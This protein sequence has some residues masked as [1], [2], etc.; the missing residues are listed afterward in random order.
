MDARL[1]CAWFAPFVRRG[2]GIFSIRAEPQFPALT[3]NG[4]KRL[5]KPTTYFQ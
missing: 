2:I 3:A 1:S 5:E 4:A